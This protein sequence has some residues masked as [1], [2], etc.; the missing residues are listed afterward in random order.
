MH[1]INQMARTTMAVLRTRLC[2]GGGYWSWRFQI[3]GKFSKLLLYCIKGLLTPFQY[4]NALA[5]RHVIWHG[6]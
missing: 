1:A 2:D 5:S 6:K 3:L 4:S